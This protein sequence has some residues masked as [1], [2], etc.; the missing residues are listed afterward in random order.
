MPMGRALTNVM[1]SAIKPKTGTKTTNKAVSLNSIDQ[2][3]PANKKY[4]GP[5]YPKTPSFGLDTGTK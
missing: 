5:Q 2:K 4:T 1:R 3:H